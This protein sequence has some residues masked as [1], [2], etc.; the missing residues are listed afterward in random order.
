MDTKI[1]LKALGD[2]DRIV[3]VRSVD[4]ADL[5][6]EVQSEMPD[7]DHLY[8]VHSPDGERLA[9]VKDREMAFMLARQNDFMPVAVH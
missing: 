3:Y 6:Q 9:L 8:A 5:P 4:F 7:V 1:D 2:A